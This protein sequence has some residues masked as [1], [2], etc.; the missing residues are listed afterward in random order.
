MQYLLEEA[1]ANMDDVDNDGKSAWDLLLWHFDGQTIWVLLIEYFKEVA[2]R[3]RSFERGDRR[4]STAG[5]RASQSPPSRA[6]G[7]PVADARARGAGGYTAAGAAPAVPRSPPHLLEIALPAHLSAA[8]C[9]AG[10]DPQR[11]GTH[12]HRGGETFDFQVVFKIAIY[13]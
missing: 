6:H 11:R 2:R 5:S 8:W 1:N 10:P 3:L 9:A 12:Y 13:Q 4:L 7:P